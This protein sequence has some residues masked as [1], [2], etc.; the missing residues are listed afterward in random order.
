MRLTKLIVLFVLLALAVSIAM[1][2]FAADGA[3][4]Y[5]AKCAMCHG[6]DGAGKVGPALKGT[7]LSDAQITDLLVKGDEAKKAPHKKA[8]TGLSADDAKAVAEY[9]KTLK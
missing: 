6:P 3:A 2:A 5:K 8:I 7:S 4:T 1:P 9:V